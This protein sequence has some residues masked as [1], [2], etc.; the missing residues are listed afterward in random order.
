M[1]VIASCNHIDQIAPE[2]DQLAAL[3]PEIQRHG[4]DFQSP[5]DPGVIVV[6]VPGEYNAG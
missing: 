1:A 3:T 5:C 2:S 4:G 6:R